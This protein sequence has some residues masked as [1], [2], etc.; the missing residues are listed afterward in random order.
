D[1][2]L[3]ARRCLSYLSQS[4]LEELPYAEALEDRVYGC[5]ICQ[6]VCPWNT[7]AQRR[8][9]ALEPDA[10]DEAFPPLREWLEADPGDLADRYRRLYIPDRD[11]R[12]LQR[13]AR[14]AG[15]NLTAPQ[16]G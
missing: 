2:V 13:N 5:D 10:V 3:D 14:A 8:A 15:A 4:R 11:G 9:S 1:G 7:G 6:D 12:Y 16:R